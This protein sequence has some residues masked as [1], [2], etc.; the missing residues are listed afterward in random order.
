MYYVAWNAVT[1]AYSIL[2]PF[3]FHSIPTSFHSITIQ[4]EIWIS[5]HSFSIPLYRKFYRTIH[6]IP[7]QFHTKRIII[8]ISIPFPFRFISK[9]ILQNYFSPTFSIPFP[10]PSHSIPSNF[11]STWF[12]I[13]ISIPLPFHFCFISR[14]LFL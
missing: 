6:S 12:V 3:P 1:I 8:S 11:A 10:F 5:F 14:Q 13:F 7:P 4:S 2:I 9:S